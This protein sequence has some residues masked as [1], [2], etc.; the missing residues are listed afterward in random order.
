MLRAASH[1][2]VSAE[3][4]DLDANYLRWLPA[5]RDASILDVGCGSGRVLAFLERRGFRRVEGF[6]ADAQAVAAAA[7]RVSSRVTVCSDWHAFFAAQP[8]T[9]DLVVLK[10]V[11]YYLPI[12]A[13]VPHLEHVR[14]ALHPGGRVIVEV[15]NGAAFTGPFVAYKD[16]AIR[17]IP[18]EHSIR[19]ALEHA[20]FASVTLAA[21]VPPRG[22]WRRRIFNAAGGVWRVVLRAIYAVERGWDEANPRILTTKLIAVAESPRARAS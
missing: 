22:S 11:L 21:H 18:T 15:F 16:T 2:I 4:A 9:Y 12:D 5:D 6:D 8:R 20:G 19:Q 7:A 1:Q 10:D 17:W 14:A 3:F 13:L